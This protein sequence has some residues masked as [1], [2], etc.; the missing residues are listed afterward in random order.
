MKISKTEGLEKLASSGKLFLEVFNH[1]T[2]SVEVYKP[3][4]TDLQQPHDRDEVYIVISGE[5][6][7]LSDGKSYV[8][9]PGDFL[10]VPS[11]I[12]HR[13]EDFT[14][15]FATWVIFFGPVG[16]EDNIIYPSID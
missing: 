2:L 13:F 14:E 16:G 8:F 6:T 10:F 3:V 7:F 1:G 11:G 15:D 9:K 4:G 5:G 12:E